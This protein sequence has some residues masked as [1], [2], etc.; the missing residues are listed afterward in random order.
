MRK[1][2]I[3]VFT[4][5]LILVFVII[6]VGFAQNAYKVYINEIRANSAST[7]STEF[8]ELIGPA[9]TNITGFKIIHYNGDADSDKDL[10]THT[11]GTFTI[12]NDGV[13]DSGGNLI[14]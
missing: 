10:W 3:R 4:V 8:I 6:Q 11:I 2:L 12:P 5:G 1:R 7:D 13:T 9:E 14:C